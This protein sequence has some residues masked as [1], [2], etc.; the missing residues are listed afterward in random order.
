MI[1]FTPLLAIAA[2]LSAAPAFGQ[3]TAPPD[4]KPTI[5]IY[6]TVVANGSS[7]G[8][9]LFIADIPGWALAENQRLTPPAISGQQP[10]GFDAGSATLFDATA[11]QTRLG[12]RVA[13]PAGKS[14]WTPSGQIE[15]DFF[16]ARPASSQGTVFNQP[17]L[18]L[19]LINL[20]HTSGW[21]FLAGQD[22]VIFAP[23]NPTSFAHYAVPLAASG[24]NPWM[25][26]PQFRIEKLTKLSGSKGVLIQAGVLRPVSGGDSPAA[27]SLADAVELSGER[28]GRP[29][30]QGRVAMTG[31]AH[32]RAQSIGVSGHFGKEKA[33]PDTLNTWGVALDGAVSIGSRIGLSGELWSGENLDTFQAGISQGVSLRQGHFS[34]VAAKGGW[35]QGS[36]TLSPSASINAGTG[37]DDPDDAALNGT[38]TRAKNQVTW[39]NLMVRA[40]TSVTVAFEY[41]YFNTTHRAAARAD[42][43]RGTGHYGNVAVV[44]SF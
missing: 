23:T 19:A 16:G 3:A 21:S 35:I 14:P 26:L 38:L 29:F 7:A 24:G 1:H 12:L 9:Q 2:L 22:W 37:V 33:E 10:T 11:R 40:H 41:N 6:G 36:I 28:S 43:H 20:K 30:V 34:T 25:R 27:G 18:R 13:A 17:R 8:S 4:D 42:A 39:I 32:G 31:A 44:L 15:V 5:T